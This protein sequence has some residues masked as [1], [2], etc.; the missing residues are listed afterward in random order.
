[1]MPLMVL[2]LF[3]RSWQVITMAEEQV[4]PTSTNSPRPVR[5]L[6]NDYNPPVP[7]TPPLLPSIHDF[8]I[9]LYNTLEMYAVEPDIET[10]SAAPTMNG[11][12]MRVP[13]GIWQFA[14][15]AGM[16]KEI[17]AYATLKMPVVKPPATKPASNNAVNQPIYANTAY[18]R[19]LERHQRA[20]E[21][22]LSWKDLRQFGQFVVPFKWYIVLAF[23]LT[24]GVGLTA[25]P[26]P[27]I[28]RT[29]LDQVFKSGDIPL[30]IWSL[31]FL[32]AV[33]LLEEIL[34]FFN[35]NILGSLSRATNL[36]IT[37]KFYKHMLRL[38]LSFFQGTASTGQALSRLSEVTS[39]QQTV[40][41]VLLDT[42]V[43]IVLVIIYT[44]V[45][46]LTDWRL[47]L[48]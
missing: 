17:S 8:E 34:S 28:F 32:L 29:M 10:H 1:M 45:L 14:D 2:S 46:F 3:A 13:Q 6:G 26:L 20:R 33:F 9:E 11:H 18:A 21:K 47:T 41:Q 19:R 39:A 31:V 27:F 40:I 38:P 5:L 12:A 43:N 48:V 4:P 36:N 15:T 30:F 42:A 24:V 23:I 25:I 35:R 22:K 44:V 37:H 16:D 7:E